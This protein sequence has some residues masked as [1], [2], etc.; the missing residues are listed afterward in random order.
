LACVINNSRA[1]TAA[2]HWTASGGA[3]RKIRAIA[4]EGEGGGGGEMM[5]MMMMSV[6]VGTGDSNIK[7]EIQIQ[8]IDMEG[9]ER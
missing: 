1:Q 5:M 9:R 3:G 7:N 2:Q 8:M 4:H 6:E